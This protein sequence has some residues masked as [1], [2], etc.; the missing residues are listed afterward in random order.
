[1][2][3]FWHVPQPCHNTG[4][5]IIAT[6]ALHGE[7]TDLAMGSSRKGAMSTCTEMHVRFFSIPTFTAVLRYC[8]FK[9]ELPFAAL[10]TK[11]G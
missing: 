11:F 3:V 2:H 6:D 4:R 1:M 7:F 5:I 9:S 10:S 8:V